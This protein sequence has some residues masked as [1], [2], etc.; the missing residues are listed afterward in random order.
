MNR[1]N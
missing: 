1:A